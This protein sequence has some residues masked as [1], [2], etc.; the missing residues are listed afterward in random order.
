MYKEKDGRGE[1]L[2]VSIEPIPE[3]SKMF[4]GLYL[5]LDEAY[6]PVNYPCGEYF[7]REIEKR[8]GL[9]TAASNAVNGAQ[10]QIKLFVRKN[11]VS[12]KLFEDKR[13]YECS[14][15]NCEPQD[16]PSKEIVEALHTTGHAFGFT[17]SEQLTEMSSK[18]KVRNPKLCI[19]IMSIEDYIKTEIL[20]NTVSEVNRVLYRYK[21]YNTRCYGCALGYET[22]SH[23]YVFETD[24]D[25]KRA[26]N[27]GILTKMI[28][29]AYAVIS[30]FDKGNHISREDYRVI[31]K[32]KEH[33]SKMDLF[34]LERG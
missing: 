7:H 11:D 32:S 5:F 19:S 10:I 28:D 14:Y 22:Y 1:V 12:E 23:Y 24:E 8:T 2:S 9:L 21:G 15:E 18:Q 13:S 17:L 20:S 33:I 26:R 31:V 25:L 29:E 6:N 16:F 4:H 27:D 30:G 34:G 3:F